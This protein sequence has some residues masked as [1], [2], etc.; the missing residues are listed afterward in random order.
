MRPSRGLHLDYVSPGEFQ[1]AGWPDVLG[2]AAFN[3]A[4]AAP[5]APGAGE[6]PV[7]RVHM[8][9]LSAGPGLYEVWRCG[10]AAASGQRHR[11]RFRCTE[12]MLFGCISVSEA[13]AR[14]A[15]DA[16]HSPLH[17][18]TSQAYREICATIDTEN[19]PH[20]LRIWNYLPD[21]N[22]ASHGSE[23]YRQFNSA[24]QQ[25][26][27]DSGRALSGNVP[28]AS[29][30]GAA[31]DSPLLVYFLAGRTPPTFVEN[32]RQVSAYHYPP[33]YGAHSPVFSRATLLRQPG[34]VTLFISGTASI[35]GHRSLHVGDTAAQTRETLANIEALLAEA[36]R[37]A[38]EARFTPGAL[39][40]KV[41]V[42]RPADLPI[43]RRELTAKLGAQARV[44][45]LQADICR[46]DL[47]VEI[48]ATAT[49]PLAS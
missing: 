30:L 31:P 48:E 6:I 38:P 23:R 12:N 3:G 4:A 36:N 10:E 22:R 47:L 17:Q 28:A 33:Q 34:S 29:A 9:M 46:Q 45:Y 2:V 43:I 42:R 19:Y 5:P 39:A 15:T 14:G 21:I 41:Y 1:T 11:V 44:V 40:C 35:V 37:A 24:R 26:L 25:A 13:T 20:L 32:P 49:G 27:R 16:A 8:P 7:A 18:A